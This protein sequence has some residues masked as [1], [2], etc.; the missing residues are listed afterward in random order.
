MEKSAKFEREKVGVSVVL[1]L[2]SCDATAVG[3]HRVHEKEG[4]ATGTKGRASINQWSFRKGSD[5]MHATLH[6]YNE[7]HNYIHIFEILWYI[8]HALHCSMHLS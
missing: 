7:F 6:T 5:G 1:T 2:G 8:L 4:A 3:N